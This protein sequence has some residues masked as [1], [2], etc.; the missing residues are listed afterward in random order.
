MNTKHPISSVIPSTEGLVLG[1]LAGTTAPLT[2]SEVQRI[3]EDASLSGVRNALLR[4]A[5]GGVVDRVPGGYSLNRDHVAAPAVEALA[6]MR[7]EL[8]RR[9]SAEVDKWRPSAA[10]VGVFGSTARQDGDEHSDIDVVVVR[11]SDDTAE[12][13]GEL[14]ELV[15]RRTGNTCHVVAVSTSDLGRMK[16]RREPL[17]DNWRRDLVVVSGDRAALGRA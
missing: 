11:D 10:L 13:V 2:L 8:F 12:R 5:S 7:H 9:M 6:Q 14:A 1:A 4:L 17:L 3:V 16:R 15:R